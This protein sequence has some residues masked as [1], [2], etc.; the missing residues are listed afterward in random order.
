MMYD[1]GDLDRCMTCSRVLLKVNTNVV[2]VPIG[3]II[4]AT[5][6]MTICFAHG[7]VLRDIIMN[8]CTG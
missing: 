7:R 2:I 1:S 5:D 3:S 6:C 8:D 4:A